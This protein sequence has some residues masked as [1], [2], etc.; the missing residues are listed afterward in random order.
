MRS[1]RAT[2][3]RGGNDG[4]ASGMRICMSAMVELDT[5]LQMVDVLALLD[6]ERG[7][8]R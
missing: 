8:I 3:E 2:S 5:E 1:D 4:F 7:S 6:Q